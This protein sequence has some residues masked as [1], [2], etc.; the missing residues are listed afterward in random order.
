MADYDYAVLISGN[1][2]TT[3]ANVEALL[4]DYVLAKSGK[5]VLVLAFESKPSAAQIWAGQLAT[6][7]GIESI[8]VSPPNGLLDGVPK[9]SL[10]QAKPGDTMGTGVS[11]LR[12]QCEDIAAFIVWSDEDTDSAQTLSECKDNGV[13]AFDLTNGLVGITPADEIEP[14]SDVRIPEAEA[15]QSEVAEESEEDLEEEELEEE[16]SEDLDEESY[17]D[18]IYSAITAFAD[19]VADIIIERMKEQK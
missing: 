10:V 19:M 11:V 3:R 12:A 8:I 1:G 18:V 2:D 5:G 9:G 7:H 16:D 17:E 6:Q 13:K 14:A 15:T 4:E